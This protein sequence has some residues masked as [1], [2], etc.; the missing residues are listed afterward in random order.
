MSKTN[1]PF[2][3]LIIVAGSLLL[4]SCNNNMKE[5]QDLA[6]S[7]KELNLKTSGH[8]VDLI[9]YA[10]RN[11]D[12]ISDSVTLKYYKP[13]VKAYSNS[14]NVPLWSKDGKWLPLGDSLYDFIRDSKLYGLFPEDYHFDQLS[15]I[16]KDISEDSSEQN[17]RKDAMLWARSDVMM[18]D[19]FFHLLKDIKLGRLPQDSITLRKDS[20]LTEKFYLQ[21]LD[22]FQKS[23]NLAYTVSK[24]EPDIKAYQL[25]KKGIGSFLKNY[26]DKVYTYIPSP[27]QDPKNYRSILQKRLYEGGIIKADSVALDSTQLSNALKRYQ[28]QKGLEADGKIGSQTLRSLNTTDRERFVRIA[29]TMDRFKKLPPEMPEKYVWVNLPAFSLQVWDSGNVI[30]TSRIVC[31]KTATRSPVL[32]SAISELITYPKWTIPSSIIEKEV[33]PGVKKNPKYFQKKGYGV[34]DSKGR[35][36]NPDSIDWNKYEKRIPFNIIQGSGDANALGVMKFNFSNKYAVYLH[37][38]NERYLFSRNDRAMSHGCIRVQAWQQLSDFVVQNDNSDGKAAIRM[39]SIQHWLK[40]KEKHSIAIRNKVPLYIRYFTCEG[41]NG[42]V[43]FYDDIYGEDKR[44]AEK[45]FAG[46]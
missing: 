25:L 33:L 28:E 39:D 35:E 38:T 32:T 23:G 41:K 15:V 17:A 9:S 27:S 4:F 30:L 36:I 40:K 24:L 44:L 34:F 18:T 3:L 19:A 5:G 29:I 43:I 37:D 46:K 22:S 45:Y 13:L 6:N 11:A 1:I 26:D 2:S 12:K 42:K 8:I 14:K 16:H 7:L 31:G 21:Q 10:K 20:V